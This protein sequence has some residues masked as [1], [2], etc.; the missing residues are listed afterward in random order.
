MLAIDNKPGSS[1]GRIIII[2]VA[3]LLLVSGLYLLSLVL[4]PEYASITVKPIEVAKL[5][6]PV[7]G[8]N[9]III[10]KIGVD[11]S[12]GEGV[13]ALDS[14]AQ[15]RFPERGNPEDGGNFIIA[16]H[17]L[18]IKPTPQETIQKSPFYQIDK[19][20]VNDEIIINYNGKRYGYKIIEKKD[21]EPTAVEIENRTEQPRLTLYSCNLEGAASGRVVIF[22]EP[23]GEV[24]L[25]A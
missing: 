21:V 6:A 19:L 24:T 15:W 20:N 7:V 3:V 18:T 13:A 25:K 9:R 14:G 4:A 22:A 23:L 1:I 16:A 5:A 10:P 11:I 8:D 2:S 17:R 12:Y